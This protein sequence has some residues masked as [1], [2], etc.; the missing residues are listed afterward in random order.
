MR[1]GRGSAR[2]FPR[3]GGAAIP[4]SAFRHNPHNPHTDRLVR[5]SFCK[6][7]DVVREAASRLAGTWQA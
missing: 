1:K 7:A 2:T 6:P 5:F 4:C 3:A